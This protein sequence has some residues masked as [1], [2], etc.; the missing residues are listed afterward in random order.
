MPPQHFLN[1]FMRISILFVGP[2]ISPFWTFGGVCPRFQSQGGRSFPC[3]GFFIITPGATP[4]DLV[5]ATITLNFR[6]MN[7]RDVSIWHS[8]ITCSLEGVH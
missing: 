2:P 5:T 6:L 1:I 7:G 3:D 8:S 4:A